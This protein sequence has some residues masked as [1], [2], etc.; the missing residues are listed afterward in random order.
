MAGLRLR[1]SPLG[2][3]AGLSRRQLLAGGIGLAGLGRVARAA[4]H[5]PDADVI[6]VGAGLA[7]LQAAL[8]LASE[9]A[10]VLVLEADVRV[11]GRIR[12]L[13]DAEGRPEAGGAEIGPFYARVHRLVDDLGLRIVSRPSLGQGM[14]IHVG[15][16]LVPA[17]AWG[18]HP[19]N[20]VRGEHRGVPPFALE[21]A[22]MQKVAPLPAPESWLEPESAELDGPYD[23]L[24]LGLGA[25]PEMLPLVAVGNPL[26]RLSRVS[27]LWMIRRHTLRQH[28]RA[29]G[30]LAFLDGGMSRLPD[31]MAARLGD[32]V[33][34]AAPVVAICQGRADV[35]VR[36]ADGRRWR[37]GRAIVTT[38]APVTA[39]LAFE[40][41]PP[42]AIA[43]AWRSLPYGQAMS[44]FL[45][46]RSRFWEE[47][48]L[49][50]SI[51]SWQLGGRVFHVENAAGSY[52]WF[53]A[54]GPEAAPLQRLSAL[55]AIALVRDRME[56]LRPSLVG[57]LGAPSAMCWSRH[58][59]ARG[60]FASRHPGGLAAL[61]E[62]LR[63]PFGRVHFAGEHTADLAMG[64]EGALESGERAALEVL[65]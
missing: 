37:A 6:V 14:A 58:R 65:A 17:S 50:P 22:L 54:S 52:L 61:Q 47:D 29:Q 2:H 35:E 12:T 21:A 30:D 20:P 28:S 39:R 60:T 36:T 56:A 62:R 11:G 33:H 43:A 10:R 15:T 34:L 23:R 45:P 64:I 18:A 42:P 24:L 19:E 51:W 7:G 49:P 38:P 40:P 31:A 27:A 26:G 63:S 44:V 55:D 13:D 9:G 8:L 41:A 57:R 48:G 5:R 59:W 3:P 1:Q 16:G 4:D 32:A 46:V 25:R 53:Y